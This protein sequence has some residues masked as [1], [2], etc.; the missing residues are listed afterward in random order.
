[1]AKAELL[2]AWLLR[3]SAKLGDYS[4]PTKTNDPTWL[5]VWRLWR[6][7]IS[8]WLLRLSAKVG[9]YSILTKSTYSTWLM[10]WWLRRNFRSAW[11]L[12]LLAKVGDYSIP[13]RMV[14]PYLADGFA[15]KAEIYFCLAAKGIG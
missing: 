5:I 10:V 15:A 13:T 1:M 3:L 8:A 12:R 14:D 6:K 2:S 7:S 11:L 9:D 4:I